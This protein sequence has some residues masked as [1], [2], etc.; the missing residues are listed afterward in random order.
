MSSKKT[1]MNLA[2]IVFINSLAGVST[3]VAQDQWHWPEKSKNLKVLPKNTSADQLQD[4]MH[5]F[6][7]GLGVRCSYCH[8]GDPE[9]P[10][11][12]WDFA[13]D[14]IPKKDAARVM[15]RMVGD[16]HKDLEKLDHDDDHDHAHEHDRDH[17]DMNEKNES[18]VTCYTCHHGRPHPRTL[19]AE[20]AIKYERGGV[21]QALTTYQSLKKAYYGRGVFDFGEESLNNF[22]YK[23]LQAG[24]TDDAIKI[25]QANADLFPESGNVWDS[26]AEAYMKSGDKKSARQYY[27][28]SLA[29]DP[30]NQHAQ[31]MLKQLD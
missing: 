17:G 2:L 8:K 6:T 26:L 7:R 31:E 3:L 5:G 24:K 4:V 16:I 29:L 22:G 13:S 21:D 9:Q 12:K 15:M 11:T 23:I 19:E 28:K 30:R 14:E 10:F 25:L 1:I 18:G 20:L 27:E